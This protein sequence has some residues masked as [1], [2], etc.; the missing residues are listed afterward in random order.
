MGERVVLKAL[1]EVEKVVFGGL[2]V[3]FGWFFRRL[4]ACTVELVL[5]LWSGVNRG[6]FRPL[7]RYGFGE[8]ERGSRLTSQ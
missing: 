7:L 8:I 6:L 3:W 1:R 4:S 5:K 2:E